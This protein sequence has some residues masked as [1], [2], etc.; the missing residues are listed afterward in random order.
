MGIVSE[1]GANDQE[2]QSNVENASPLTTRVNT[3]ILGR[4]DFTSVLLRL[5][6]M[7]LY[8]IRRRSMSKVLGTLALTLAL[9]VPLAIGV[10]LAVN[11]NTPARSFAPSCTPSSA[12]SQGCTPLSPAA[13]Q[14]IKRGVLAGLSA[15]LRLPSALELA[16]TQGELNPAIILM[17]ILVGSIAGGEM[18]TG[19]VRLMFTRGPWRGQFLLAKYGAALVCT[20]IGVLGMALTGV[21][22]AQLFNLLSG[23]PQS[24]GFFTASWLGHVL[25]YLLA[26]MLNWFMYAVVAIFFGV[27]GRSTS[28]GI[29]GAL[30]WFF[31]EPIVS[32]ILTIA[33]NFSVGF[34]SAFLRA[35][36]DYLMGNNARTLQLNQAQYLF[37][38]A[39]SPESNLQALITLAVYLGVF[40][41]LTWWLNESRDVTN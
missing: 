23:V 25:L 36:P 4:M 41:G 14:T 40:I 5:I 37:G 13:L 31:A 29:V 6:G 9:L 12:G 7:E 11:V 33:A 2:R 17:I 21:I 19:T 10:E 3:V 18:G 24:F 38:T 27:L 15:P 34:A 28:A 22:V 30:T 39:G 1:M 8:K 16:T 32:S 26:T 35:L 20:V